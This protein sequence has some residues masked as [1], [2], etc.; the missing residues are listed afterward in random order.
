[1]PKFK[2]ASAF[3]LRACWHSRAA[4]S[5]RRR[6]PKRA[7]GGCLRRLQSQSHGRRDLGRQSASLSR[8]KGRPFVEV[9]ALAES[10]PQAAGAKYGHKEKQGSAPWTLA[11][12]LSGTSSRPR[13]SRVRL[14]GSRCERR[15][16][17]G[18]TRADRPAIRARRS[19]TVSTSSTSTNSR[20]RSSGA[21]R[22]GLQQHV[23]GL[24]LEKLSRDGLV[25]RNSTLSAPIP[26]PA[27]GQLRCSFRLS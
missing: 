21:V 23:N 10:D 27:K 24:V 19:A 15:R 16:Q 18:R 13:R 4:R 25:G 20:T 7:A 11:A 12:R 5:S 14:C 1:M 9:T 8:Q 3:V 26:L 22:Q 17:G 2:V 6:L